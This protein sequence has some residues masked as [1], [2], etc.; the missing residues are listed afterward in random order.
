MHNSITVSMALSRVL[1]CSN[2]TALLTVQ[3]LII[4]VQEKMSAVFMQVFVLHTVVDR[5]K[6]VSLDPR[7]QLV[8]YRC[9]KDIWPH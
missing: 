7:L 1:G 6:I 5:V 4:Y 2:S 9:F 8:Q 3:V